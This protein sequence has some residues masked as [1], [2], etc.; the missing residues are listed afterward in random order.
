MTLTGFKESG[1]RTR[2]TG[3]SLEA[4][5]AG[6]GTTTPKATHIV[7]FRQIPPTAVVLR[8]RPFVA[9]PPLPGPLGNARPAAGTEYFSGR[10][11]ATKDSTT[12]GRNGTKV[13]RGK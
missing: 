7:G 2:Q 11:R 10:G 1:V 4:M 6:M 12:N 13:S 3:D 8:R 5:I 9:A